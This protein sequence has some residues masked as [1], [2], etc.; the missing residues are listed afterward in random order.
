MRRG[1]PKPL[2]QQTGAGSVLEK[3][4]RRTWSAQKAESFT[5]YTVFIHGKHEQPSGLHAVKS[6]LHFWDYFGKVDNR[7]S[8]NMFMK[9]KLVLLMIKAECSWDKEPIIK[10][11]N[12]VQNKS[13]KKN[14]WH[15][16]SII[17]ME[18]I[19]ASYWMT[20]IYCGPV[21]TWVSIVPSSWVFLLLFSIYT[22]CLLRTVL[23]KTLFL[24]SHQLLRKIGDI[25]RI[26][27]G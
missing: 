12:F 20:T 26:E 22:Y 18:L 6:Q 3:Q 9:L 5:F 25:T 8:W 17:L 1:F 7:I 15:H 2:Y 19:K 24:S 13:F 10:K 11:I 16:C 27:K 14:V 21:N 4:G 23:P